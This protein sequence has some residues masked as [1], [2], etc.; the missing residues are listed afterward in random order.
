MDEEV[1][2]ELMLQG[3]DDSYNA[4]DAGRFA[5][6]DT[7]ETSEDSWADFAEKVYSKAKQVTTGT[8]L[9]LSED[10]GTSSFSTKL[11]IAIMCLQ[12][13]SY[14]LAPLAYGDIAEEDKIRQFL[15]GIVY[16]SNLRNL[17]VQLMTYRIFMFISLGLVFCAF[18]VAVFV[19][20]RK[21]SGANNASTWS[22]KILRRTASFLGGVAWMPLQEVFFYLLIVPTS[23]EASA[24]SGVRALGGVLYLFFT[25]FVLVS[26]G[27]TYDPILTSESA[28]AC[29]H[30]RVAFLER[31]VMLVCAV[32]KTLWDVFD[33]WGDETL[34]ICR[35]LAFFASSFVL[36]FLYIMYQPYYR[37]KINAWHAVANMILLWFNIGMLVR[38]LK[39]LILNNEKTVADFDAAVLIVLGG[40]LV[41]PLTYFL[42]HARIERLHQLD[43]FRVRNPYELEL[44]MRIY[45]QE[46]HPALQDGSEGNSR[47]NDSMIINELDVTDN[48]TMF[49][50]NSLQHL[51]S[52]AITKSSQ[53]QLQS[54]L[55]AN[56]R[57]ERRVLR[58]VRH[59]YDSAIAQYSGSS[60]ICM[61]QIH[62]YLCFYPNERGTI[63]SR[64]PLLKARKRK[65]YLD[66]NF[67]LFKLSARLRE[68]VS[69]GRDVVSFVA[70]EKCEREARLYDRISCIQLLEFWKE[71]QSRS[72]DMRR[73]QQLSKQVFESFTKAQSAYMN[74]IKL[75]P[76]SSRH[77]NAYGSFLTDILN[78]KANG[79]KITYRAD[80]LEE[81]RM[82]GAGRPGKRDTLGERLDPVLIF[83]I[84]DYSSDEHASFG[85][86]SYVNNDAAYLLNSV[87]HKL[88]GRNVRDFLVPPFSTHMQTIVSSFFKEGWSPFFG[89]AVRTFLVSSQQHLLETSMRLAPYT[90]NGVDFTIFV[91]LSPLENISEPPAQE[92][93]WFGYFLASASHDPGRVLGANLACSQ[94]LQRF[95]HL[96]DYEAHLRGTS[97][98]ADDIVEDYNELRNDL[99]AAGDTW[100]EIDLVTLK[101]QWENRI[102]SITC[103]V[104]TYDFEG[105]KLDRISIAVTIERPARRS[106]ATTSQSESGFGPSSPGSLTSP[107]SPFGGQ[108]GT[109][110]SDELG[111]MGSS[112][113][114]F[115]FSSKSRF[116]SRALSSYAR[117]SISEIGSS[118][119]M[120]GNRYGSGKSA[121]STGTEEGAATAYLRKMLHEEM[122]RQHMSPMLQKLSTKY[123]ATV[124]FV[125]LFSVIYFVIQE[126]SFQLY[127]DEISFLNRAGFRRFTSVSLAYCVHGLYLI[128]QGVQLPAGIT[129]DALRAELSLQATTLKT[130][131]RESISYRS[132]GDSVSEAYTAAHTELLE[133]K[134][135]ETEESIQSLFEATSLLVSVANQMAQQDLSAFTLDN[136]DVYLLLNQVNGP[137][138]YLQDLNRTTF[139]YMTIA[140]SRISEM[141]PIFLVAVTLALVL[142]V[143]LL[144]AFIAPLIL[145]IE[146]NKIEVLQVLRSI[147]P[148]SVGTITSKCKSRLQDFHDVSHE[149][150]AAQFGKQ[151]QKEGKASR[152]KKMKSSSG[153]SRGQGE[154]SMPWGTLARLSLPGNMALIF[155]AL[156]FE[157]GFFANM[158]Y[159]MHVPISVNLGGLRRA[160]LRLVKHTLL[161]F[162]A[163]TQFQKDPYFSVSNSNVT[164]VMQMFQDVNDGLFNGRG[165]SAGLLHYAATEPDQVELILENGCHRWRQLENKPTV[166][167]CDAFMHGVMRGG[168]SAASFQFLEGLKTLVDEYNGDSKIEAFTDADVSELLELEEDYLQNQFTTSVIIYVE[169]V[170]SSLLSG[171]AKR[172][173]ILAIFIILTSVLYVFVVRDVLRTL[174]QT[175][176]RTRRLLLMV[177]EELFGRL[178]ILKD[179]VQREFKKNRI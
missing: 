117:S 98:T 85:E 150:L 51:W 86:I 153:T 48:A 99:V 70:S 133:L 135:G 104:R 64:D 69:T 2:S 165:N 140:E 11:G 102:V 173:A 141:V 97:L 49:E 82:K 105:M 138:S 29:A 111:N 160:T 178:P 26:V 22:V 80:A 179:F 18:V 162:F 139:E 78:D 174:D 115:R 15:S 41:I 170:T 137:T 59:V 17:A 158:E 132:K 156:N 127:A 147:P 9:L 16:Y 77:L 120:L 123:L 65:P 43:T 142:Q 23:V 68:S 106:N 34:E 33:L 116:P 13:I 121:S 126:N 56:D 44:K 124:S 63:L 114:Q 72:Q 96:R 110:T 145:M 61:F 172:N 176:R 58:H 159:F 79:S 12:S 100:T 20:Y 7:S 52:G 131:E 14:V 91:S 168:L 54:K 119:A 134:L 47:R 87:S 95:T 166:E 175:L 81:E 50:E 76:R 27:T 57:E 118:K 112:G 155:Y 107:V 19:G 66:L 8:L 169:G 108:I 35:M 39:S 151:S 21:L 42:M 148:Y 36:A 163:G 93:R 109:R 31:V 71:F 154:A 167:D 83:E 129:E 55:S 1:A 171:K 130:I 67:R 30:T 75:Q 4:F 88:T 146:R 84:N 46:N 25:A 28:T 152:R 3:D 122:T 38:S 103:Q 24:T 177:P 149:A 62:F 161:M 143:S 101:E 113:N 73:I 92:E 90:S 157:V 5:G 60:M 89:R 164:S 53:A 136:P 74:L 125:L 32:C 6:K 144:L 45:L 94:L 128:N 37:H 10:I 40:P